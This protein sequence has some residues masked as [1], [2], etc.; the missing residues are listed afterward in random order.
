MDG[1]DDDI[2]GEDAVAACRMNFTIN[3]GRDHRRIVQGQFAQLAATVEDGAAA[4]APEVEHGKV[5][6]PLGVDV[7]VH[8]VVAGVAPVGDIAGIEALEIPFLN[9][10]VVPNLE[11][12]LDE[13]V[14]EV[15]VD[16][17]GA[18]V[19]R[20]RLADRLSGRPVGGGHFDVGACSGRQQ[21]F[22]GLLFPDD[23]ASLAGNGH[24]AGSERSGK[25]RS[26]RI[27]IVEVERGDVAG[28]GNVAVVGEDGFRP[29][30][31]HA[32]GLHVVR[33]RAGKREENQHQERQKRPVTSFHSSQQ[34]RNNT[35]NSCRT[36]RSGCARRRRPACRWRRNG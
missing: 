31:A 18:D 33:P 7:A 4:L 14:G 29:V 3:G 10:Q 1:R 9:L 5:A 19:D 11:A 12:G 34:N 2:V 27:G 15:G 30:G 28:N 22:P 6:A 23:V 35:N 36:R 25:V 17:V 24:A 26:V 16:R 32:G 8:A 21:L 13:P 20:P